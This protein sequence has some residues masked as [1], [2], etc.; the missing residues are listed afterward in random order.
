MTR[1][2]IVSEVPPGRSEGSQRMITDLA[3]GLHASG[4]AVLYSVGSGRG[5]RWMAAWRGG[6]GE[7]MPDAE[8]LHFYPIGSLT[9][10]ALFRAG[11]WR[12][13]FPRAGF[14][15][16]AFQMPRGRLPGA[17]AMRRVLGRRA[18]LIT[19][20]AELAKQLDT[21]VHATL[22]PAG[23]DTRVFRL[24]T[25]DERASARRELGLPDSGRTVLHVGHLRSSRNLEVL[26]GLSARG[27]HVVVVASPR[28]PPDVAVLASLRS[29]GVRVVTGE[30][31]LR[32]WYWGSDCYV[33][34][35]SAPSA[36]VG[37]PLS[38]VEALACG[39]PVVSTRFDG[40]FA[41]LGESWPGLS[42]ASGAEM[43]AAVDRALASPPADARAISE[44]ASRRFGLGAV[45]QSYRQ[46]YAA[47]A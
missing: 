25:S 26:A 40:L 6:S 42:W 28:F 23:V 39:I 8:V 4:E 16:H 44:A 5:S 37:F 46:A 7:R 47:L 3:D 29:A 31:E 9:R 18:L 12:R 30:Q 20:S 34:P 38:V 32:R 13:A 10:G 41:L 22:V 45:V 24:P 27:N 14:L 1:A 11:L 21:I 2:L 36:A 43:P 33:F 35:V 19:P 15:F 17:A